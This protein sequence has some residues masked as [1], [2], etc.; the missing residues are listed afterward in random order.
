VDAIG[1]GVST[2]PSNSAAQPRMRFPKFTI[3]DMVNSQHAM[4]TRVLG[5]ER[6]RAV[7]GISM[8]GMQTFE[9]AVAYPDFLEKGIPIVGSPQMTSFDLLLWQ[10]ELNA[11]EGDKEWNGGDYAGCP[12]LK[13]LAD[14]HHLAISTPQRLVHDT[15]AAVFPIYRALVEKNG[16]DR[17]D[18]NNWVRQLQAMMSHDVAAATGGSLEKAAARVKARLLVI[19]ASQDHMVNPATAI[20][21]ARYLKTTPTVSP[22]DCGHQ[23]PGCEAASISAAIA[24]FLE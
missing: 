20:E 24:R 14:I 18:A 4:L 22:S 11:I 1:D 8:G 2:S 15:K 9:W 7:M 21:F 12:A 10:A 3:R 13:A 19:V 5:L 17:F 6:L 16:P 23:L